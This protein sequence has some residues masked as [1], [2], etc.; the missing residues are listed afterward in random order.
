MKLPIQPPD[1]HRDHEQRRSAQ[2]ERAD[3]ENHK[4]GRDIE[5]S[6]GQLILTSSDGT[7][8]ALG[9]TNGGALYPIPIA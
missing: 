7:R 2:I 6:P 9:V 1:Y 8:W 5:V 3:T 4:R